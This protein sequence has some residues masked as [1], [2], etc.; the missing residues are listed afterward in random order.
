[1]CTPSVYTHSSIEYKQ[2]EI[3]YERSNRSK[4]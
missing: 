4:A 2:K 3:K 1:M